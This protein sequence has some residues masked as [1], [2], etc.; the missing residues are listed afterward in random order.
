MSKFMERRSKSRL[1]KKSIVVLY[2]MNCSDGFGAAYA[3]WKKFGKRAEYIPVQHQ[4]APPKGLQGKEIYT[5]D[6]TYPLSITQKILSYS[7]R[8]TSIDHHISSEK[9]TLS[10]HQP[11]YAVNHSGAVLSWKYFHTGKKIPLLLSYIEDTDLWKFKLHHSK[12]VFAYL[13][14]FDFDFMAWDKLV[15]EFER[16]DVRARWIHDGSL[17][18]R[19]ENRLIARLVA[20][21]KELVKFAG[22]KIYAINSPLF[23]SELGHILSAMKP[24]LA[25]VWKERGGELLVSLRSDGSCDVSKIAAGFGGGGHRGAAGFTISANKKRP[26]Q[27]MK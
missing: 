17:L 6:F 27:M 15:N 21:N 11:L 18:L 10:T 2:H 25:L 22:R 26:W 5:I 24:P 14:L 3:A 13:D 7:K 12:E 23:Q 20:N 19:H 9:A 16:A 4:S 8:L 1:I